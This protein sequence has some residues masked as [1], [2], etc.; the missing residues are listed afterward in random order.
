MIKFPFFF[1]TIVLRIFNFYFSKVPTG[2]GSAKKSE[3]TE[4]KIQLTLTYKK[5]VKHLY[6]IQDI[7]TS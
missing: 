6:I 5:C 2:N 1:Y 7:G 4:S 3:S